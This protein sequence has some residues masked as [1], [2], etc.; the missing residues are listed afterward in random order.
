MES[1]VSV[2]VQVMC[3]PVCVLVQ[4]IVYSNVQCAVVCSSVQCVVCSVQCV[5]APCGGLYVS[6]SVV[7][8]VPP[9]STSL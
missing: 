4:C 5:W 1:C 7:E 6:A 9:S 3:V 2:L 8:G